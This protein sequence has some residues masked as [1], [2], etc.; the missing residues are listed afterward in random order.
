MDLPIAA[1]KQTARNF[2]IKNPPSSPKPSPVIPLRP[3]A[4]P[5]HSPEHEAY[6]KQVKQAIGLYKF[7]LDPELEKSKEFGG[8]IPDGC[9]F[10]N[11][12]G[13]LWT[14]CRA[15]NGMKQRA[16]AAYNQEQNGKSETAGKTVKL[17]TIVEDEQ[18]SNTGNSTNNSIYSYSKFIC[19]IADVELARTMKVVCLKEASTTQISSLCFIIDLGAT[20]N[21]SGN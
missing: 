15:L 14:Q 3:T 17:E 5:P 2:L 13:H 6:Q 7:I 4:Y 12:K 11:T 10:C 21:M 19:P 20:K 1:L 16:K 9:Y 18:G 8:K